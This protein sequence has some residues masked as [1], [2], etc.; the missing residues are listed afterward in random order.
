LADEKKSVFERF[1]QFVVPLVVAVAALFQHQRSIALAL[2]A[3]GCLSLVVSTVPWFLG[4]FREHMV[5]R[6]EKRVV[7]VAMA[8]IGRHVRKFAQLTNLQN[9][10]AIYYIVF[11]N[12]C[13][14]NMGYYDSLHV[15][16]PNIFAELCEQLSS[17]VADRDTSYKSL[18]ATV[19]ELTYL[20]SS[21][22]R[23]LVDP[24]YEEVPTRLTPEVLARYTPQVEGELIQY[25][26]RFVSFK[27]S[28]T[29]FLR[30]LE[31]KL[32]RPL[33]LG[34]Y[35]QGPK[36]LKGLAGGKTIAQR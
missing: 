27:D 13:G 18:R 34:C 17:R 24:V 35:I 8:E 6:R 32:P 15:I 36:P 28:Y 9:T 4:K 31:E 12:L 30:E 19:N 2:I 21:F 7:K 16:L 23:Y 3:F 11:N 26:E 25:R 29:D 33:G 10:D 20:V 1:S 5:N 22:C 14:S